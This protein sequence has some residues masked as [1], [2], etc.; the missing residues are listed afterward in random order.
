MFSLLSHYS[1]SLTLSFH[2]LLHF[3]YFI[4]Q[5]CFLS[6][7]SLC[8]IITLFL[9]HFSFHLLTKLTVKFSPL[10]H[11]TFSFHFLTSLL[12]LVLHSTIPRHFLFY[13]SVFSLV[14]LL[15]SNSIFTFY[16]LFPLLTYSTFSIDFLT[17]LS[18]SRYSIYFLSQL[19][20]H[21]L[22]FCHY[23]FSFHFLTSLPSHSTS[24]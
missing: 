13:V 3:R 22:L 7:P 1:F 10:S 11:S 19:S 14:S 5:L 2:F 9:Y 15:L 12:P 4:F 17:L 18:I 8:F 24:I 23:T 20:F 16:F 21:F 6:S